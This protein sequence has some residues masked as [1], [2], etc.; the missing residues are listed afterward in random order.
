MKKSIKQPQHSPKNRARSDDFLE[1][2]RAIL[3]ASRPVSWI[4]TAV[5]FVV[6]YFFAGGQISMT[7][8]VLASYFLFPY[9]IL[10]YGVNDIF[11]YESDLQND[12]KGGIEGSIVAPERRHV[13]W[14]AIAATT[15]IWGVWIWTVLEPAG[16]LAMLVVVVLAHTYSLKGLRFKEVPLLDS[17]NSSLHFVGPAFIGMLVGPTHQILDLPLTAFFFWGVAS[18][19]LGAIQDIEPDRAAGIRSIATQWGARQ[20]IRFT[21][22]MYSLSCLSVAFIQ[23]PLTVLAAVM[24]LPYVLNASFFLKY[25]SDAR[26]HLYRRGWTNFMWLNFIVGFWL[27]QLILWN[28]DP[29]QVGVAK[30]EIFLITTTLTSFAQLGLI[31]YNLALF[32]RP[33]TTR[34]DEWPRISILIYAY[35]Q[36]ENIASTLLAAL[37]QNYPD[38]EIL[39]VDL[40]S[41]DNTLK[42]ARSYEDPKLRITKIDPIKKGWSIQA[43]AADQLIKK[44]TGEYAVLLSADTVLHP[45]ALAQ[46]ASTMST[47]RL[48]LLSLLPADQNKSLAQKTILSH[49]QYLLLAAYPA[50]YMQ[51]H[52]PERSTVHGGVLALAIDP[53]RDL[54]GFRMVRASPLEEHELFHRARQYGLKAGLYRASDLAT[55]QNHQ[56]LRSILAD[57]IQRFYPALR[58]HFPI[59]WMLFLGGLV[60]F[61]GPL[62]VAVIALMKEDQSMFMLSLIAIFSQLVTRWVVAWESKQ[63]LLAQVLAPVTNVLVMFLLLLSALQYELL[64]PR[65]QKRTE[66]L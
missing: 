57:D 24:L 45:N 48:Q 46:I 44:A 4:N 6:A 64:K 23:P 58:F 28:I 12:R 5:P 56:D 51:M 52:A 66:L 10:L 14:L 9:N 55:S 2:V 42:I 30:Y 32:R 50:A 3:L 61:T 7:F 19:A 15:L 27:T 34:L 11:D 29:F 54:G 18:H 22:V 33:A 1:S 59:V 31:M 60:L 40:S 38:F 65:W 21:I 16:L 63:N 8:W 62:V 47:K 35:N 49:N 41:E 43:W 20:T 36:V 13:I 53:V 37:G 25:T 39:F 17:I 26:S